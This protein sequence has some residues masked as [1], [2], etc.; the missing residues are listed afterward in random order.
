META[1]KKMQQAMRS[2]K[3]I[4]TEEA[5][6]QLEHFTNGIES[7]MLATVSE[8]GDPFSSYAPFVEDDQHNYYVVL[9]AH[10][11]HARNLSHNQKAS[12][13]F[14][15]DESKTK[16]IFARRRLYFQATAEKFAQDDERKEAIQNLFSEKF[17]NKAKFMLE[18]PDFR[19]YKFI[20]SDGNLVLGFGA[21]FAVAQDRSSV[22]LK[23]ASHARKH[24]DSL[25]KETK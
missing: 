21:A 5:L 25:A 24:E 4:S 11:D 15:E 3:R 1:E 19:I 10:V 14:I 16:N 18:M 7:L 22:S 12:I 8:T 6:E 2:I 9:S 17:G 20:P 13:L 23:S